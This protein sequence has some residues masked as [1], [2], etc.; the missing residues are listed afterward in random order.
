M[1][2]L[3]P[4]CD[5]EKADYCVELTK[6]LNM[7]R[8]QD[9]LC[10]VTLVTNDD[11][12]FKAHRNVLSAASP[13]FYKLLETDMK[14]NR[15]GIARFE[16]ITGSVM[17]DVLEFVY[18]GSVEVTQEN[19][20]DLIAAAN[21]LILPGLK[22]VSGRFLEEQM[23]NSNCIS[24]FYFAEKYECEELVANSRKFIHANFAS[25]A[26]M[27]EFLNFEAKEVE[28]WISNDD[29][30]VAVEADVFEIVLKWVEQ[31]KS[32]RKAAFEE[33]FRH[34]RLGYLSRDY[35]LYVVT[36]ELVRDNSGCLR[37]TLDAINLATFASED[38]DLLQSPRKGLETHGIVTCG[39]KYTF[40]YLPEKDEWKRLTDGLSERNQNTQ[41]VKFLYQ[42]YTFPQY[43]KVERYDPVFNAW[44]S[45]DLP[46]N[47]A[48]VAVLGGEMYAIEVNMTTRKSIIK[49]FSV[50]RCSWLTVLS[51]DKGCRKESCVV[52]I[53]NHLYVLGGKPSQES[54]YIPKVERFNTVENKWEE[55]SDMQQERGGAFGV[56]TQG[57]IF[58]AGG[59]NKFRK[60]TRTCE[61][62]NVSTNEWQFIASLNVVRIYGSMVCLNR[63]LYVL[64]GTRNCTQSELIV[65]CYDPTEDKWIQVTTIPV[66]MISEESKDTFTGCVLKLSKGVLDKLCLVGEVVSP[67]TSFAFGVTPGTLPT[68]NTVTGFAF[69]ATPRM[70]GQQTPLAGSPLFG[71]TTHR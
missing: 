49:R 39:G 2:D 42:L 45:L 60:V 25:V 46:T 47:S 58:I 12:E 6:R 28:R 31:N 4:I 62:Y 3:Q 17:E 50:E 65:E 67:T 48:M 68:Q 29:I 33:L 36:N 7:Q 10:D 8:K 23:S 71:V 37:L 57:K 13:F 14:E 41:I 34:V 59:G 19:S 55:I 9:H 32:E 35:L 44:C 20:E 18:T 64:G 11:K 38:D 61:M 30:S 24:T 16:E 54:E 26:E 69:G 22:T 66:K 5:T 56:A 53:G 40:C 15:E 51:S 52:A 21:Y 1:E 70:F 27:D 63:K 43:S